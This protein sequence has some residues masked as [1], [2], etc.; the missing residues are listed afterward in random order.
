VSSAA[1]NSA[2]PYWADE[3]AAQA[4][5]RQVVND[6]KTP[7]GTVHVGSLR[8][9]ILHDAI[10]RVV[11]ERGAPVEFRYGVEDLDPMD[12]QALLTPDAVE[13]YMGVPLA[14]VPPP[15]GS[16]YPNY[17]RHFAGLFLETFAA[18]GIHPQL[19]WMSEQYVSGAMDTY[20]ERALDRAST[21]LEIYRTVS[22]VHHPADWLPISVVCEACGRIGTTH[23][24]E[25]DGRQVSY[26]CRPDLV[27]W[28]T[29]CGNR[30]RISPFGGRAKLVW[31]VDWAA[32]W[33]LVGATIEGCGK[34]LA[35]AGG[36]RDRADAISRRVFDREPPLNVPYEFLN[37]GG[38]KMSTS[39]GKGAAAHHMAEVLPP[40]ILRF[41]FLR[42]RPN[43]AIEFDPA[44]D[45][46]PRL[47]DEYDRIADA[48]AG[49]P[50]R[51]ELPPNPER[52]FGLS[53]IDADADPLT[54]AA[55]YRPP[56]AHLALLLQVPGP[57]IVE[58]V[59]AEK[60]APLDEAETDGLLERVAAA[61]AWLEH[62][63]PP[64]AKLEI[65]YDSLPAGAAELDGEQRDY[66][67]ALAAAAEADPPASG[68]AWQALLFEI[69]RQRE[70][71]PGRAFEAIYRVVLDRPNGPRAG[72]LLASLASN[73]VI[74]RLHEA[75]AATVS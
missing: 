25:W 71:R 2:A 15:A 66:L 69:A 14:H 38:R 7:S 46:I 75:A 60:G 52:I 21:I 70:L 64:A 47:F 8:G 57:D 50:V 28:A 27:E 23:A 11:A 68:E 48:V 24:S 45:T 12:A 65:R 74:G 4:D 39:K 35:T 37:I 55:R 54:E 16:P 17:A 22:T 6:S 18:L 20:I 5:G 59:A 42:H 56:F 61:R 1:T 63:A 36:S 62:L 53:M 33:G 9:V 44:G 49:R 32:R 40:T 73:F 31:N 43:R 67:A 51:G 30:G 13:R 10:R 34:D 29:G 72:W 41:L 26:E 19:Y 3:V 58:R